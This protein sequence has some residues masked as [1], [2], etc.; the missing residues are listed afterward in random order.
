MNKNHANKNPAAPQ[1]DEA[2]DPWERTR[3]VP[4]FVVAIVFALAFWGLLTYVSEYQAQRHAQELKQQRTAAPAAARAAL[5]PPLAARGLGEA[6]F[7]ESSLYDPD[8]QR[9]F[10]GRD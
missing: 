4:L 3:P 8:Y 2:F 10:R 7:R 9:R 5:A 1:V 6:D